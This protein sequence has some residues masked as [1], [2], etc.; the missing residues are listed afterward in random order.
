VQLSGQQ[1]AL[2]DRIAGAMIVSVYYSPALREHVTVNALRKK[3][4]VR[5]ATHPHVHRWALTHKGK[6][7]APTPW[8]HGPVIASSELSSWKMAAGNERR[9][10]K[11]LKDDV[12]QEWVGIGWIPTGQPTLVNGICCRV[13]LKDYGD[14]LKPLSNYLTTKLKSR[15]ARPLMESAPCVRSHP[16]SVRLIKSVTLGSWGLTG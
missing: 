3:G 6:Q 11:V 2:V 5:E 4:L 12:V 16:D 13:S 8:F 15:H 7:Y 14:V 9:Y 1:Q 10:P